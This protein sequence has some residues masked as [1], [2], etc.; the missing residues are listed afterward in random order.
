MNKENKV[1]IEIENGIR[2]QIDKE[3]HTASVIDIKSS[4][5]VFIPRNAV[6][7][8]EK[9]KITSIERLTFNHSKINTL[10]FP[11]N[12]EIQIFN[13][14][15][16]S[17]TIKKLQI[18]PKLYEIDFSGVDM[19]EE[20]EISPKNNFFIYFDNKYLLGKTNK[21]SDVFDILYFGNFNIEEAII[22]PQIKILKE[23]SF[24]SHSKLKSI[25]I[26]ENSQLQEIQ[27]NAFSFTPISKLVLPVSLKKIGGTFGSTENLI[28]IEIPPENPN[29]SLI[30]NKFLLQK[31]DETNQFDILIFCRRDVEHVIIPSNIK[32]IEKS[33]ISYCSKLQSIT[34]EPNSTVDTLCDEAFSQND[35]LKNIIIPPSVKFVG[36]KVFA[37][38]KNLESIEFLG[39]NLSMKMNSF[40]FLHDLFSQEKREVLISFPNATNLEFEYGYLNGDFAKVVIIKVNHDAKLT[41]RALPD[42][43]NRIKYFG[44]E[45]EDDKKDTEIQEKVKN[46]KQNINKEKVKNKNENKKK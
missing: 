9:Y 15:F 37:Y 43:Q 11:T 13:N 44:D 42:I 28:D 12:S 32:R 29:F 10:S 17:T 21:N 41:G 16:F 2:I 46:P 26:P 36:E 24:C 34:F 30:E 27:S 33:S 19:L 20:I 25:I 38:N 45:D 40:D 8:G 5:D 4:G 18:P 3:N 7:K 39:D 35:L 23:N 1:K 6:Y 14:S 22:P 31:N